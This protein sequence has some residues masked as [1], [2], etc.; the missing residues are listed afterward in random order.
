[1]GRLTSPS[2]SLLIGKAVPTLLFPIAIKW[3]GGHVNT[4]EPRKCLALS[5]CLTTVE[6]TGGGGCTIGPGLLGCG[7][8]LG[9]AYSWDPPHLHVFGSAKG[10]RSLGTTWG[11]GSGHARELNSLIWS[12]GTLFWGWH[13]LFFGCSKGLWSRSNN[14][15]GVSGFPNGIWA[16]K[17]GR[18]STPRPSQ[19]RSGLWRWRHRIVLIGEGA[20]EPGSG[21]QDGQKYIRVQIPPRPSQRQP[22]PALGCGAQEGTKVTQWLGIKIGVKVGALGWRR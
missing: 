14:M 12:L 17:G 11:R 15:A 6:G 10:P 19:P 1:M 3:V 9:L 20:G 13:T 5:R 7:G 21:G 8:I 4:R 16:G 22:S 2:C 18:R